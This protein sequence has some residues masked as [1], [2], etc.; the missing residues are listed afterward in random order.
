MYID[1]S[2]FIT[3]KII[4]VALTLSMV[5]ALLPSG[6]VKA[7]AN[8]L[9]VTPNSASM[10]VGGE[11][12]F[13]IKAYIDTSSASQTATGTVTY[14]AGML[15]AKNIAT[16]DGWSG[17]PAINQSQGT[18]TFSLTRPSSNTGFSTLFSVTFRAISGGTAVAGFSGDSR[19]NN[20]TTVYKSSSMSISNPAPTPVTPPAATPKSSVVPQP[21]VT[22]L[23]IVSSTPT[24]DPVPSE[25]P[26]PTPD[27]TGIVDKVVIKP[28]YT[29]AT[30][31]WAV[32]A[33]NP[34]TTFRYGSSASS[35]DRE[36]T[37]QRTPDGGFTSTIQGLE[38]GQRY[39]FSITGSGDGATDGTYSGT[40]IATG[41]PIT[42]TVAEN[43]IAVKSAQVKIGNRTYTTA[44]SGKVSAS[45]AA[46][47]YT[48]LVTTE[49]ASSSFDFTV[50]KKTVPTDG[51]A[52]EAQSYSFSLSSSA[53]AQ[54]P[55]SGTTILT[56]IG[57]LLGGTVLMSFGFFGF[58]AYRRRK[59]ETGS[60]QS[61][62]STVIIDD[63][64][65]WRHNETPPEAPSQAS[66][67]PPTLSPPALP[68]HNNSVYLDEEEP[69]DMFEK[70]SQPPETSGTDK[71]P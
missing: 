16:S 36:G 43:T 54:G 17:T 67:A 18:I 69:L 56:F 1:L 38:P 26:A 65:D 7:A 61:T 51:S 12:S 41:Y 62:A 58:M 57:V 5:I 14:T 44:S 64:Y 42:I 29:S 3:H 9:L 52:P 63:G 11:Q 34:K 70:Q 24:P 13:L 23:P 55:G 21:S 30:L 66:L 53:L 60:T 27:P 32:N 45:L 39:Y 25:E 37:T 8:Q 20:V 19:V 49:T 22:P 40:I 15:Q 50:A 28:Q 46:G 68:H 59:F 71:T 48:A 2:R 4:P 6:I 33:G 35:L 47:Q 10:T 31:T